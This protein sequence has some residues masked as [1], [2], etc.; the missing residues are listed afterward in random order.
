MIFVILSRQIR[1]NGELY[2]SSPRLFTSLGIY[3]L[4]CSDAQ[5]FNRGIVAPQR[6]LRRLEEVES[7]MKVLRIEVRSLAH[8]K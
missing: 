7:G 4:C 8:K 2:S 6:E 3:C 5:G 1:R